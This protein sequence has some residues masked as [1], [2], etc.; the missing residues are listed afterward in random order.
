[1]DNLF[2][3]VGNELQT[4]PLNMPEE[5]GSQ[6]HRSTNLKSR[7]ESS[8]RYFLR[9]TF[10][11]QFF[12]SDITGTLL[13]MTECGQALFQRTHSLTFV[14]NRRFQFHYPVQPPHDQCIR[15]HYAYQRS[16]YFQA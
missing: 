8:C 2:R 3:N 1:M 4:K 12:I 13:D 9:A 14:L 16:D 11:I 10:R 7:T 5:R 15:S 6:L